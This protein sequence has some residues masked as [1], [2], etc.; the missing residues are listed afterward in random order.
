VLG[1]SYFDLIL[2]LNF[3]GTFL[4]APNIMRFQVLVAV[5][6]KVTVFWDVTL[7]SLAETVRRFRDDYCLHYQDTPHPDDGGSTSETSV[8]F[9][10]NT[11]PNIS[12]PRTP[13]LSLS[14]KYTSTKRLHSLRFSVLCCALQIAALLSSDTTRTTQF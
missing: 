9:C 1:V 2:I 3:C 8:N 10:E 7:F 14:N 6:M 5:S 12:E 4:R 11:R 13:T